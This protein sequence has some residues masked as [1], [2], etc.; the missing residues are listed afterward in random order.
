MIRSVIDGLLAVLLATIVGLGIA[1]GVSYVGLTETPWWRLGMWVAGQ[2]LLGS[3]QQQVTSTVGAGW[4]VTTSGVPLLVTGV[5]ALFVAVRAKRGTWI[6]APLAALGAAGGSALLVLGSRTSETVT[7][8]AGSVTTTE[9][10]TWWVPAGAAALVAVVWL[11]HTVGLTWWRSGRGVALGLLVWLGVA[12][13][14]AVVAGVIYLT[15]SNAVGIATA[16]LYPLAGTLVLFAAAGAPVAASLTRLTP[17]VV[18][19]QSWSESVLYG[20]GGTVAAFLLAALVGVVLRL[21]KH[22]STWLGALT[23]TPLLAAFLAWAMSTR[24]VVPEAFGAASEIRINPL[25]AAAVGLVL[26]GVTRFCAG[27][28]RDTRPA[29]VTADPIESLLSEVQ[30]NRV[31]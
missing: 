29:P 9:G 5:V 1:F 26:A 13:T 3:W 24:I 2:G 10:L 17:E 7:N 25:L 23:L 12:L 21:F 16:L 31:V 18:T 8:A 28:P 6:G 27:A 4:T 20:I 11:L 19:L 15:S 22:K 30:A 14:G